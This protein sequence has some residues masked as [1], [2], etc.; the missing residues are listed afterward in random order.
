MSP[1]IDIDGSEIQDATIDGQDVLEVTID[2]QEAFQNR[3]P[4]SGIYLDDF[5]DNKLFDRDAFTTTPLTPEALEPDQS[6]FT[7]PSRPEYTIDQGSPSAANQRLEF[8][9][10][11]NQ[12]LL[13]ATLSEL[14]DVTWEFDVT[15]EGGSFGLMKAYVVAL[16]TNFSDGRT[17]SPDNG[18]IVRFR[19]NGNFKLARREGGN[20]DNIIDTT[21]SPDTNTH[22]VK[23]T[24]DSSG[25]FELFL[26]DSLK[27]TAT[28]TTHTTNSFTGF[29]HGASVGLNVD[30]FRV[31]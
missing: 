1:P 25:N 17:Q 18:Y 19:D 15:P 16:D 28:D 29:N 30:N 5:E 12:H 31:F 13:F 27:G 10:D 23:V 8:P 9:G 26:D 4:A 11:G 6:D 21:F 22:T 20:Q 2:G 14:D 3:P 7:N 24:R